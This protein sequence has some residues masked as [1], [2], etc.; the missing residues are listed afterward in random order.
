LILAGGT[1][2][3]QAGAAGGVE[4]SAYVSPSEGQPEP[5]RGMTFY[6]LSK[7][8]SDI[9]K[10]IGSTE[11]LTDLD[12]F[13]EQL[14][15]SAELKSWIKKHRRI[16]LVGS[17]FTKELTADD[18]V[19]VPEFLNAYMNQNGAALHAAIPA[20][21]Y[22]KGEE[23]KEPEKYKREQEEYRQALRRFIQINGD[24]IDGLDA[25][26]RDVNPYPRWVLLQRDQQHHLEQ[27]VMQVAQ[28][29]YLVATTTSN[30]SGR[31]SFD[32]VPPGQYWISNLDTPALAGNLRLHWDVAVSVPAAKTA[33]LELSNLN[34]VENSEQKAQ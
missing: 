11:D 26:L 27:R 3:A 2:A 6:L 20:P 21:K 7:S 15:V 33:R 25:E 19:G 10:E 16:D 4:F 1:A 13:V 24:S 23:Q 8:L 14:D 22:K 9:R 34:V 29:H 17:A 28:T 18:V 12:H 30:L 32:N 5:V 31:A